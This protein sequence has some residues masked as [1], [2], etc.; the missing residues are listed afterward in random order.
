MVAARSVLLRTARRLGAAPGGELPE[1]LRLE[2]VWCEHQGAILAELCRRWDARNAA[3]AS[4]QLGGAAA[5][6]APPTSAAAAAGPVESAS[7]VECPCCYDDVPPIELGACSGNRQ[8]GFCLECVRRVANEVIG[9]GGSAFAC[10]DQ[11]GCSAPFPEAVLRKALPVKVY[12]GHQAR[13][14][15][16]LMDFV[17]KLMDFVLKLMDLH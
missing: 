10:F 15:L 8:H 5:A 17:L 4:P 2:A 1:A 3:A 14:L 7:L 9:R 12:A 11:S 16:K 13:M 6:A